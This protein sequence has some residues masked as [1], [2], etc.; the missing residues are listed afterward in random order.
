MSFYFQ[1]EVAEVTFVGANPKN[2]AENKV[3]ITDSFYKLKSV[4]GP[5]I[6][7]TISIEVTNIE[8]KCSNLFF[9]LFFKWKSLSWNS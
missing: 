1:G 4:S 5:F 2:S 6:H 9:I 3:S 7:L 8:I